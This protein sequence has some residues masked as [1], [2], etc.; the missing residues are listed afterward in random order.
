MSFGA[1][2]SVMVALAAD[3][4]QL[5]VV[6]EAEDDVTAFA[7][8]W[9]RAGSVSTVV[10]PDQSAAFEKAGFDLFAGRTAKDGRT[11]AYACREFLCDLPVHSVDEIRLP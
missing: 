9:R 10:T 5:V 4:V 3:P 11:T 7:R 2:L 1:A 8:A 6:A